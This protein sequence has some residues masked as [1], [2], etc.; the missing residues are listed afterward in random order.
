MNVQLKDFRPGVEVIN[1]KISNHPRGVCQSKPFAYNTHCIGSSLIEVC[2]Y[3]V[4]V[5]YGDG[6]YE[7]AV[8][9]DDLSIIDRRK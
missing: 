2:D 3:A 5:I 8:D 4:M 9:V 6:E 7:H 1:M